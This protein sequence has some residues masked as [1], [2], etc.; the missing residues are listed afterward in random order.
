LRSKAGP[1]RDFRPTV[2]FMVKV[3]VIGRAKTRLAKS[4]G[5]VAA[6]RFYRSASAAVIKR[7]SRDT[8]WRTVLAVAPDHTRFSPVW[9]GGLARMGQGGGGLGHRMQ[10]VMMS[11]PPGPV[12]IIG[13][14]IP[15][16]RPSHVAALF[17]AARRQGVAFGPAADGGYWAVVLRRTPLLLTPFAEARWSTEH[18][19]SDTCNALPRGVS[20]AMCAVLEDVDD[21]H[22]Y[23]TVQAWCGRQVLPAAATLSPES[24]AG[25]PETG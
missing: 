16:V 24:V 17:H 4:I 15:A 8:R 20:P 25:G 6:T 11:L 14:D 18:A 9:P 3:P 2:V 10:A 12:A 7:I 23:R 1:A 5:G 21:A 19:L 22:A 13:T